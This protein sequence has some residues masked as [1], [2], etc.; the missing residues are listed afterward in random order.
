ML[1]E[2]NFYVTR[3]IIMDRILRLWVNADGQDNIE[4]CLPRLGPESAETGWPHMI[5]HQLPAAILE[6]SEHIRE[7]KDNWMTTNCRSR[8]W[9]FVCE[10]ASFPFPSLL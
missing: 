5:S 1:H 2:S 9:H 8:L 4:H 10:A 3:E 6:C 7:T